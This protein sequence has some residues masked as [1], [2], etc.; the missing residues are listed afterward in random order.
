[1][2]AGPH[3]SVELDAQTAARARQALAGPDGGS[4]AQAPTADRTFALVDLGAE[5]PGWVALAA[6]AGVADA[7]PL[8][9]ELLVQPGV[10]GRGLERDLLDAVT[11][12]LRAAGA[13]RL[14]MAA[15]VALDL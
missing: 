9:V 11:D 7:E 5:P 4:T 10:S 8:L 12:R 2:S 6:V 1:M 14:R 15:G 13:R 3:V